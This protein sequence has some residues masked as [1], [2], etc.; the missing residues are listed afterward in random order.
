MGVLLCVARHVLNVGPRGE[1]YFIRCERH[2]GRRFTVTR[3]S[4]TATITTTTT[5]TTRSEIHHHTVRCGRSSTTTTTNGAL[6]TQKVRVFAE[7]AAHEAPE[8]LCQCASLRQRY[9]R[10]GESPRV[11]GGEGRDVHRR[12]RRC[13]DRAL[14]ER[15]VGE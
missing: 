2:A 11:R 9:R 14:E 10:A 15:N 8:L 7:H 12:R 6:L 3:A 13:Q 5:T 4:S 1:E